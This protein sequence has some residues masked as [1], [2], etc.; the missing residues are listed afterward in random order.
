M[1]DSPTTNFPATGDTPASGTLPLDLT[2]EWTFYRPDRP[3]P[4]DD[5]AWAD[6]LAEGLRPR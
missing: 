1:A 3:A 4:V 2:G 6:W 5:P